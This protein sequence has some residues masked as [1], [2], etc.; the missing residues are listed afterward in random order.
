MLAG[1]AILLMQF[2]LLGAA[3]FVQ[4]AHATPTVT[5]LPRNFAGFF[6]TPA[7]VTDDIAF[8]IL[9]RVFGIPDFFNSCVEQNIH[10]FDFLRP[11]PGGPAIPGEGPFPWPFH[12]ALRALL[13]FYSIGLLIVALLIFCY[14][15]VAVIMETAQEG[16]PFGRR[17]NHVWAP[18]RMVV[19]LGLLI[20]LANGLNSAQ[21]ITLFAAY[22]GSGFAT[23]GWNLFIANALPTHCTGG[24][25]ACDTPGGSSDTLIGTPTIP[26]MTNLLEFATV[27]STCWASYQRMT[28]SPN[29]TDIQAYI[30]LPAGST[31]NRLLIDNTV[32]YA[33]AIA[34]TGNHDIDVRFG[35]C[36]KTD[37][38]PGANQGKTFGCDNGGIDANGNP[39]SSCPAA[40]HA[41]TLFPKKPAMLSRPAAKRSCRSCHRR[42][43]RRRTRIRAPFTCS[44]NT[45]CC[46][47]ICG[48]AAVPP[49]RQTGAAPPAVPS[50]IALRE[51][52]CR[53]EIPSP[54]SSNGACASRT[55]TGRTL[56]IQLH[57]C[58]RETS[59]S[60]P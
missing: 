7:P 54:T 19:A 50:M 9:D 60:R 53:R 31:T 42:I 49:V 48:W 44:S 56:R 35:E 57:L 41:L 13:Q 39:T 20:P 40:T 22:W 1:V 17:F 11:D 16:T 33:A 26:E 27:I 25:G 37:Q 23:N 59:R 10:C 51:Q 30:V 55:V 6:V 5:T 2:V 38:T 29:G 14:F 52:A 47:K 24:A 8:V 3:L 28:N 18:I 15:V 46:W 34:F 4:G 12:L 43:Q 36:T 58:R 32:D 45:G 21:Y